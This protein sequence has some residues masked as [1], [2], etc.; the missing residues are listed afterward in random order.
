MEFFFFNEKLS[1]EEILNHRLSSTLMN[2]ALFW[3]GVEKTI[4]QMGCGITNH[5]SI[6]KYDETKV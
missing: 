6:H 1:T 3:K 2:F 5:L 4:A